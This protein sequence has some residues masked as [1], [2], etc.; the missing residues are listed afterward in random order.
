MSREKGNYAEDKGCDFLLRNNFII[1]ER[2]F[3]SRFG[4]IDIIAVKNEVIHFIEVK[5]A[6]DFESAISN[7]TPKKLHKFMKTLHVYLK[8]NNL[9][10]DYCIDALIV[11]PKDIELVENITL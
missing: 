3:Y 11:T 2:N 4:E 1:V 7:I 6:L 8:K 10:K 9:Q 5:S